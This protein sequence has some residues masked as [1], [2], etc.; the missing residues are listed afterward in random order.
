MT[1]GELDFDR[2]HAR[3]TDPHTSHAAAASIKVR[4]SQAALLT[5]LRY[6]DEPRSDNGIADAYAEFG[7][8]LNL[9]KQSPSGLRTRRKELVDLGK[10]RDTGRRVRLPSGR[11]SIVWEAIDG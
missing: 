6:V 3:N 4:E 9:P 5:I 2:A 10:V 11:K 8:G 1:Q 7:P